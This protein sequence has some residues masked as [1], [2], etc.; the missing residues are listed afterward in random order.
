MPS[1]DPPVP[2]QPPLTHLPRTERRGRK[3]Y[4]VDASGIRWRVVPA[5]RAPP[6]YK[7]T[8]KVP[9]WVPSPARLFIR[10]DGLPRCY[11]PAGYGFTHPYDRHDWSAPTLQYQLG[12][13]A[14]VNLEEG[15]ARRRPSTVPKSN[16]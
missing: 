13:A 2:R 12:L 11:D 10:D 9:R 15:Q 3:L 14:N 7:L 1:G 6:D 5:F 16:T 8:T 4:L